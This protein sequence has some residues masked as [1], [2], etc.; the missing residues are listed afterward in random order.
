MS[1]LSQHPPTDE[2]EEE[3]KPP[4]VP[5]HPPLPEVPSVQFERPKLPGSP[6]PSFQHSARAI[7]LA[8]SIG[9]ALAGPIIVGA[10]V[11]YWLD[12]R[13]STS[14]TWTVILVL[15]GTVAGLVQLIRIA[16]RL[17]REE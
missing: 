5:R 1:N 8:F 9:F 4:E 17:S 15:L 14:P 10:L 16:S 6:S 11:G 7:S 3:P 13:F 12:A 2:P